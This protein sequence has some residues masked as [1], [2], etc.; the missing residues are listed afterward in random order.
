[1]VLEMS[2]IRETIITNG[3]RQGKLISPETVRAEQIN[4]VCSFEASGV[5]GFFIVSQTCDIAQPDFSKEPF[6]E[7]LA[8]FP[9]DKKETLKVDG[10]NARNYHFEHEGKYYSSDIWS[11]GYI[12]KEIAVTTDISGEVELPEKLTKG[13][14]Q[15]RARRYTRTAWPDAFNRRTKRFFK[16]KSWK[17]MLENISASIHGVYISIIPLEETEE[18][19]K[20]TFKFVLNNE[21]ESTNVVSKITDEVDG[22]LENLDDAD[23]IQCLN[24]EDEFLENEDTIVPK[25][26]FS[27]LEMQTY[28]RWQEGDYHSANPEND[29]EVISEE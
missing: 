18:D 10:R 26:G 27:I 29:Q 16:S 2:D 19:Y 3:W 15:W 4:F 6:I 24:F 11:S 17:K 20:V 13:L 5:S 22:V 25:S 23:G 8:V 28:L 9:I 7:C 21:K 14:A 12:D 1:M